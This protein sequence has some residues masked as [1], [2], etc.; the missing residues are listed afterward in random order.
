MQSL[1]TEPEGST[2]QNESHEDGGSVSLRIVGTY[3][4]VHKAL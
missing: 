4:Q 1:V 3:G 2:L